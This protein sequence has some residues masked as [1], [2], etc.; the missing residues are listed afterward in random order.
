MV[1]T[2][3][4]SF[5]NALKEPLTHLWSC[6]KWPFFSLPTFFLMRQLAFPYLLGLVLPWSWYRVALR[7]EGPSDISP[8]E[9]FNLLGIL[10]LC[11]HIEP[12]CFPKM[13]ALGSS[14]LRRVLFGLL[15]KSREGPSVLG[16]RLGVFRDR[17]LH[18]L[19]FLLYSL[20]QP[21][22]ILF[23]SFCL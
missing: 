14:R 1:D 11:I 15:S 7:V 18:C 20:L 12:I 19:L 2:K 23:S 22:L 16:D 9:E 21:P 8:I 6:S 17:N 4:R 13:R 3:G 10:G 5:R